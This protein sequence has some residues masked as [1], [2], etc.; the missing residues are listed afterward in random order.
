MRSISV[1]MIFLAAAIAFAACEKPYTDGEEER[2]EHIGDGDGGGDGWIID[3]GSGED[4]GSGIGLG[5]TVSVKTFLEMP[6]QRQVWVK[7]Y[8]VGAATGA[9]GNYRYVFKKPFAYDTAILIA[10]SPD[11]DRTDSVASVCLT[12]CS[13]NIRELLNLKDNP[14]NKGKK[15]ALFGMQETYLRLTGIKKIDAYEFPAK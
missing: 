13:K 5:D 7:G 6:I 12:S 8:I 14:G 15:V 9:G 1:M 3:D 2:T 11:E 10:G 4:D